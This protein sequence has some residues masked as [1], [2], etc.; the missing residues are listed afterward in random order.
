MAKLDTSTV[1]TGR[2][3]SL[4]RS[5][6]SINA[7]LFGSNPS[8]GPFD[9]RIYDDQAEL[10]EGPTREALPRIIV[11]S[12]SVPFDTEQSASD[13]TALYQNVAVII[14]CLAEEKDRLLAE[15]LHAEVRDILVS[16]S[17]TNASI[18]ASVLVPTSTMQPAREP[19]FK[20]AWRFT[21]EYR[22]QAGVL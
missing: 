9:Y 14:S 4:L 20:N 21:Q 5:N 15:Q 17:L 18:I 10:P 19:A 7:L 3:V 11:A 1:M 8:V 12:F 22:C 6:G 16:T 13:S 2:V